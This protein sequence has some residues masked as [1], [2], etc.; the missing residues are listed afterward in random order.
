M[1]KQNE[2]TN[3]SRRAF[4]KNSAA[5]LA[6]FYIVPR[7]V[8]G[9]GFVAP[10]DTLHIATI[11][12]GGKGSS[13][14]AGFM[15]RW[16][17]DKKM[18]VPQEKAKIAFLCD[19]DQLRG[20][21]TFKRYPD[22]KVYEDWRELLDKEHKNFDA[23]SVSTPDHTHAIAASAAI[24]LGKHI[25]VQKPMTH[26]IYEARLLAE[27]ARKYKVVSQMGNQG[28]SNDGVRQMREWYEAG[29]IG[30][31]TDV[32]CYTN[33]PVWPQG[34]MKWPTKTGTPP[35]T[36]NWNLWQSSAKE[37][38]FPSGRTGQQRTGLTPGVPYEDDFHLAP[39]DWR[40]WWDYGTGVI[41][42]MGAHILEAPMTVLNLGF[43]NAVQTSLG[44]PS[45][46]MKQE[47]FPDTCPPSSNT[48]LT[49]ANPKKGKHDAKLP[50]IRI[51]WMDGG[52][53][54]ARPEEME[55]TDTLALA[56]GS[57]MLF[58]GTKGKMIAGCYS[59]K[60]TLLPVSRME[61]AAVKNVPVK[62]PRIP[63]GAE[64]HYQQWVEA[65]LQGY[66][67]GVTS[68]PFDKAAM[69]V[70][71]MLVANL[72]LRGYNVERPPVTTVEAT[73]IVAPDGTKRTRPVRKVFPARNITLLWDHD[74]MKITNCDEVNQYVKR[75]YRQGFGLS[76][77]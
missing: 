8:L 54:P 40:G 46:G 28:S 75:E 6:A 26:D 57:G 63:G 52:L 66:G 30:D 27:L 60:A 59:E 24:T 77:V 20:A 37:K 19:V 74:Q 47:E 38:P 45:M 39:H 68:S 1:K 34:G 22:A 29:L 71:N 32:Y 15:R 62:Y 11:G 55:P 72:A 9:K 69:V 51:H 23:V 16:D 13:D 25:W 5:A 18:F 21:N 7:H 53:T 56:D 36:F 48:I 35:S 33:R 10:S 73:T 3:P 67:K 31:V 12:A 49:F 58:I 50:N 76:G 2:V 14:T 41:G 4:V 17:V 64:A 65:C 42:D 43:V 70:E 61:D 44:N